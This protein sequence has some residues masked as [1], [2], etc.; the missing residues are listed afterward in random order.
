MILNT[1]QIRNV[2]DLIN[3]VSEKIA[4]HTSEDIS[5]FKDQ[6]AYVRVKLAYFYGKEQGKGVKDFIEKS[7]LIELVLCVGTS[8][9]RYQIFA[10]Y[11]EA[12]V[13]FHKFYGGKDS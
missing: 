9:Q 11:V 7:K 10:K 1:N 13:A 4:L 6:I 3:G 5:C 8:K 12:L 2:L